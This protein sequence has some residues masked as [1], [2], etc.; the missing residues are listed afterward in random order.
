MNLAQVFIYPG[1]GQRWFFIL[2]FVLA[3]YFGFCNLRE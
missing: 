1:E 2:P 3:F